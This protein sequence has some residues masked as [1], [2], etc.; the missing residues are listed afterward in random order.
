MMMSPKLLPGIYYGQTGLQRHAGEFIF[1]LSKYNVPTA[2]PTHTHECAY[3][4]FVLEGSCLDVHDGGEY[5]IDHY[6][7]MFHPSGDAHANQF[8][9]PHS[10]LHIEIL[11][12]MLEQLHECVGGL[13]DRASYNGGVANRLAER[14][15]QELLIADSASLLAMEGLALELVAE[16]SRCTGTTA[17]L[18]PPRWLLTVRDLLH[19]RF[20]ENLSL[21]EI[22][23]AAGVHPSHLARA[24]R[25]YYQCTVGNYLRQLRVTFACGQLANTDR[26]LAEVAVE[27]GFADQSHFIRVFRRQIGMTPSEYRHHGLRNAIRVQ[28]DDPLILYTTAVTR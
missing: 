21:G 14:I 7:L 27:A 12:E 15:H 5:V 17:K 1:S 9:P 10:S 13:K 6:G 19:D 24:F 2:L 4:Y 16:V 25:Q 3:F 20:D 8:V 23:M 22:A 11:S 28:K 26:A 18:S